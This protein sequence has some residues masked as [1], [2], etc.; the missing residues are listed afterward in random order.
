MRG[1]ALGAVG[2]LYCPTG[3]EGIPESVRLTRTCFEPAPMTWS[4]WVA[5]VIVVFGLAGLVTCVWDILRR[6]PPHPPLRARRTGTHCPEGL[7]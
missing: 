4:M 2:P 6:K 3:N 7:S 5:V 1:V